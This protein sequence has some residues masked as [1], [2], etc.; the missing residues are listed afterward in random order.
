MQSLLTFPIRVRCFVFALYTPSQCILTEIIGRIWHYRQLFFIVFQPTIIHPKVWKS[1]LVAWACQT[2]A[3]RLKLNFPILILNKICIFQ[4][5]Y[6]L[7]YFFLFDTALVLWEASI[8]SSLN[9]GVATTDTIANDSNT[10]GCRNTCFYPLISR[11]SKR[12]CTHSLQTVKYYDCRS[13]KNELIRHTRTPWMRWEKQ[14]SCLN[15]AKSY[16]N[17]TLGWPPG[18]HL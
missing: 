11:L 5:Q 13:L 15:A 18:H 9:I 7:E 16:T 4:V 6:S 2:F 1:S 3:I 8:K 10:A 17:P 14:K 12:D